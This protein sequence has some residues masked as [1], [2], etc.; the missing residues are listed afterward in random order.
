MAGMAEVAWFWE[1]SFKMDGLIQK[2]LNI[3]SQKY[4]IE[5]EILRE[6]GYIKC[7]VC[8]R[9]K[10]YYDFIHSGS[11]GRRNY[12]ECICGHRWNKMFPNDDMYCKKEDAKR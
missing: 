11:Y 7:P 6:L 5:M 1:H 2:Y 4:Q 12:L 10:P 9:V 8:S 3:E